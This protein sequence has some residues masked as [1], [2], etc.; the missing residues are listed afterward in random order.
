MWKRDE[1]PK[2]VTPAPAPAPAATPAHTPAVPSGGDIRPQTARDS[3]N[4]GNYSED[5][6]KYSHV[7]GMLA[8]HTTAAERAARCMRASWIMGRE[9][10]SEWIG[11][12]VVLCER[13]AVSRIHTGSFWRRASRLG[14]E[15]RYKPQM[16]N[17]GIA[18]AAE[19][20]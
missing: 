10:P 18:D 9:M 3:V 4:I 14:D 1:S 12:E 8:L 11:H 16:V 19:E 6:R 13:L 2:P 20:E 15:Y 5:K 7:T 17:G